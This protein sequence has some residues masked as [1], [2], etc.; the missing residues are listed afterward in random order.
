[1]K[2]HIFQSNGWMTIIALCFESGM[3][4]TKEFLPKVINYTFG[5]FLCENGFYFDALRLPSGWDLSHDDLLM[6]DR[7][8]LHM[9]YVQ[10]VSDIENGWIIVP[11]EVLKQLTA[12]QSQGNKKDVSQ[13]MYLVC[14]L[15]LST[16]PKTLHVDNDNI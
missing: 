6:D 16:A 9:L 13:H 11:K 1:M 5:M 2:V 10:M 8:G 7:I 12:L 15:N 3:S 14:I 4:L